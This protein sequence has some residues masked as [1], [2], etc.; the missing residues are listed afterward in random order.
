M[1]YNLFTHSS[2]SHS[3]LI[4]K[5]EHYKAQYRFEVTEDSESYSRFEVVSSTDI[6]EIIKNVIEENNGT[7]ITIQY[8]TY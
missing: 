4:A 7:A 3:F 8:G 6:F 5:L 2:Y 1:K